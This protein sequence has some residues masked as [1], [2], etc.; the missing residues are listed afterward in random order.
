[1]SL[2]LFLERSVSRTGLALEK[3]AVGKK[4]IKILE[5]QSKERDAIA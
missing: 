1:M 3:S 4:K 2:V 5:K